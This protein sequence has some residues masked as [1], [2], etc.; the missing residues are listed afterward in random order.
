MTGAMTKPT[1]STS[2]G[3]PREPLASVGVPVWLVVTLVVMVSGAAIG[4]LTSNFL[5]IYTSVGLALA[6][7]FAV[8][9][10]LPA[11]PG[12]RPAGRAARQATDPLAVAALIAACLAVVPF[13]AVLLG[14]LARRRITREGGRGDRIALAAVIVGY[15]ELFVVVSVA[16]WMWS[17]AEQVH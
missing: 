3:E 1:P 7:G 14:H 9:A 4:F 12:T 8:S 11:V 6:G 5:F 13:A 2:R 17:F 16:L 10:F 15:S